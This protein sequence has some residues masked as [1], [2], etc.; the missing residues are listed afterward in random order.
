LAAACAGPPPAPPSAREFEGDAQGGERVASY[1]AAGGAALRASAT[2]PVVLLPRP[3]AAPRGLLGP[4][5]VTLWVR[6]AC[7]GP[8]APICDLFARGAASVHF[9]AIAPTGH[10]E[11]FVW[12]ALTLPGDA[13]E[14]K[15]APAPLAANGAPA[16]ASPPVELSIVGA[17][18]L[19]LD[20][21][22]WGGGAVPPAP[23]ASPAIWSDGRLELRAGA[24]ATVADPEWALHLLRE[25]Y[26]AVAKLC[27]RELDGPIVLVALSAA[28]WPREQ[29]GAFQNGCVIFLRD[30]ELH[31]PWRSFAHEIAHLF[32]EQSGVTLPRFWSEGF[33]CAV[34]DEVEARLYERGVARARVRWRELLRDGDD[35]HAAGASAPNRAIAWPDGP[36][37]SA[38]DRRD[39]EWAGAVVDAL[40]EAGGAAFFA[41]LEVELT[42]RSAPLAAALAG[43]RDESE[44]VAIAAAPFLAA[45]GPE[46][47]AILRRAGIPFRAAPGA[48]GGGD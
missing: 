35:L 11:R 30:R 2:T 48:F 47:E 16:I 31:L 5:R 36:A 4:G 40:A 10:R 21:F 34:A 3:P 13:F 15:D 25:Q 20:Q 28:Q 8:D 45:A 42:T 46:G 17:G 22:A 9:V 37:S 6:V 14:P 7:E 33:A 39:Y 44:R 24:D 32:E 38:T 19:F 18:E 23:S 12:Q 26:G 27:G 29:T 41:R 43:T 1:T